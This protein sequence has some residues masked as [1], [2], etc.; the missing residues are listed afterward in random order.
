MTLMYIQLVVSSVDVLIDGLLTVILSSYSNDSLNHVAVAAPN[1]LCQHFFWQ[2][3]S[4][5]AH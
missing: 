1:T 2:E 4:V 3:A 5:L